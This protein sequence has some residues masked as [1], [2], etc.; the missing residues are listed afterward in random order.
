VRRGDHSAGEIPPIVYPTESNRE[1]SK[2]GRFW[3]TRGCCSIEKEKIWN[4][5]CFAFVIVQTNKTH[6]FFKI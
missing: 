1:A 5:K 6:Y 3:S 2:T 4:I